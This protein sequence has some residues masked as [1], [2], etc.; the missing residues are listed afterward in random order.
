MSVLT[1]T[2]WSRKRQWGPE[3][4]WCEV[5]VDRVSPTPGPRHRREVSRQCC[6]KGEARPCGCTPAHHLHVTLRELLAERRSP[7]RLPP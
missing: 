3:L 4:E 5:G 2:L 1:D 6:Q 7:A